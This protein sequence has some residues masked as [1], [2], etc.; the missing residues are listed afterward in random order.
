M[1][2]N[3]ELCFVRETFAKSQLN[4]CIDEGVKAY[5]LLNNKNFAPI[6]ENILVLGLEQVQND[7]IRK[8]TN[9]E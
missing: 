7:V 9:D 3:A 5:S 8:V 1:F 2:Y 6:L 4:V